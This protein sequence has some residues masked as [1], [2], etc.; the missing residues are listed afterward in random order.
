MKLRP[1]ISNLRWAGIFAALLAWSAAAQAPNDVRVALVIGNSA[2][3]GRAA[4]V[5]PANDASAMSATLKTLG[6]TVIEVKD[7]SHAQMRDAIARIREGLRGKQGIGMLYYAGHGLQV[8]FRN[9]MVP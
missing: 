1:V 8:D 5:N 3:A 7:G 4:L 6:F 2:Y 9:Y